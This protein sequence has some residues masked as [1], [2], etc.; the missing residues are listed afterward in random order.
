MSRLLQKLDIDYKKMMQMIVCDTY[1]MECMVHRCEKCPGFNNLHAH[2]E[3]KT[4]C[5]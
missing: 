4:F 5:I 2:L 3:G 1:N